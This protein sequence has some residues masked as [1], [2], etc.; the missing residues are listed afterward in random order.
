MPPDCF[1]IRRLWL[2]LTGLAATSSL[3]FA[4]WAYIPNAYSASD[5]EN[6]DRTLGP[7]ALGLDFSGIYEGSIAEIGQSGSA[8]QVKFV[9][10][11]SSVRGSYFLGGLC[12]SL[13]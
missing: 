12:G 10:N 7:A 3:A 9:R 11:G 8:A 4:T 13:S 2:T 5:V 6:C 1:R